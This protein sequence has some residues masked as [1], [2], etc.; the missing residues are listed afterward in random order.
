MKHICSHYDKNLIN[1]LPRAGFDGRIY[2]IQSETEAARAVDFLLC[3]PI[4]GFDTETRPTFKRGQMHSVALLQV[5]SHDVCFLFRLNL[6]HGLPR[7]II[8]LLQDKKVT[9]VGLSLHDDFLS[10]RRRAPFRQGTFIE[11][12]DE[13]KRIG[14]Q[15]MSLQKIF[16]ILFGQKISKGQQL[17]NWEADVLTEAQKRYAATDAWACILIYE[18]IRQLLA[19]GDYQ[20]ETTDPL[21]S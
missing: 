3:Q 1:S 15:D 5:A 18:E 9:K 4:L 6:M 10:L 20:T 11:L 16:A 21:P 12:Q 13:V 8:T 17:S 14:I 19:T 2:I 7:P